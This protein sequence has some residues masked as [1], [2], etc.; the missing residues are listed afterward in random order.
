[1]QQ[2]VFDSKGFREALGQ[3]PTGVTIVTT[4]AEDDEPIGMTASS[5]N[6]VSL[7]PP[8]ILWSI[9]HRAHSLDI[10]RHCEYFAV[11]MLSDQQMPLSNLF[12]STGADKFKDT[13]F[14]RGH[15]NVPL[16]PNCTVQ[17]ECRTWNTYP[18][19][20]HT[21]I[22]G[23][24]LNYSHEGDDSALAFYQGSYAKMDTI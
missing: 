20:D 23:E 8:L 19:G 6:S 17:L 7:D 5:F 21:I 11:N 13:N 10:F 24:V 18:G 22:I 15:G 16:L 4:L 1:M 9:D 3:F 14:T 12:A 2:Q